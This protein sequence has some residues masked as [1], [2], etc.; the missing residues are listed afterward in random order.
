VL[1]FK[2]QSPAAQTAPGLQFT[3]AY[4]DARAPTAAANLDAARTNAFYVLNVVHDVAYRY[5]FTEANFNFQLGNFGK[6]GAAGDR[7]LV[8]VQ[9]PSG[10]NNANF[11]TPPE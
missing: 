4:D 2:G 5:G 6:G 8:Q 10:V 1:S 7:V 3:A 11:A 9:D